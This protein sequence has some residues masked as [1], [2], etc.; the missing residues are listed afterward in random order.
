MHECAHH[1]NIAA[2]KG[3]AHFNYV[4]YTNNLFVN[5]TVVILVCKV[6]KLSNK[7]SG[8]KSSIFPSE[9]YLEILK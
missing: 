5:D 2:G 4:T 3:G 7:Y 1:F 8:E 6:V 9:I